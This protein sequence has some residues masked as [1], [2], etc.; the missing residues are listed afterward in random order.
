MA[1]N[2]TKTTS[3]PVGAATRFCPQC[4]SSAA[5]GDRFCR[6]CGTALAEPAQHQPPSGEAA[7]TNG[8]LSPAGKPPYRRILFGG[9]LV[10][11]AALVAA[12]IL[13]AGGVIS[14]GDDSSG[15]PEEQGA[16]KA[17]LVKR[18]ELFKAE[19]AYLASYGQATSELR[20]YQR[21]QRSFEAENKRIEEEFA[22]EFDQC[23]R[24]AA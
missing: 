3:A 12:A 10:V 15:S 23:T 7:G 17:E 4:G 11:L 8:S 24:F 22:D 16:A 2:A 20:K 1:G 9:G 13:L 18:D 5:D 21:A 19:R 14:L 6:G